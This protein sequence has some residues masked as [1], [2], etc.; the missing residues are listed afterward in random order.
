MVGN[1]AAPERKRLSEP[2][3]VAS[4][5]E[6]LGEQLGRPCAVWARFLRREAQRGEIDRNAVVVHE[7][8]L[9]HHQ[10]AMKDHREER[11]PAGRVCL[12]VRADKR[13][14][15]KGESRARPCL[16]DDKHA[17]LVVVLRGVDVE[18]RC[19]LPWPAEVVD[20]ELGQARRGAPLRARIGARVEHCAV[21]GCQ[22]RH[23]FCRKVG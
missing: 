22:A 16:F 1:H 3:E 4:A 17:L 14:R 19:V 9:A 8:Y 18:R 7:C 5:L 13:K 2:S 23:V 12:R 21:I 20:D 6:R 11:L 15:R 10:R